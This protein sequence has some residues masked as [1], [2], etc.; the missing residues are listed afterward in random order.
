MKSMTMNLSDAA[1]IRL[2]L[3]TNQTASTTE[4]RG[5]AMEVTHG[6]VWVTFEGKRD[7]YV[8]NP[9][10]RL[11]I[12]ERG[13]IVIQGLE[14]SEIRFVR[15][16]EPSPGIRSSQRNSPHAGECWRNFVGGLST[17]RVNIDQPI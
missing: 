15:I 6:S 8:L 9:G 11:P 1:D 14:Q 12:S 5:L 17:G 13:R 3:H 7:D 10:E 16:S 4:A 2:A